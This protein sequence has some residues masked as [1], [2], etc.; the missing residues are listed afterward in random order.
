MGIKSITSQGYILIWFGLKTFSLQEGLLSINLDSEINGIYIYI[1]I[2]IYTHTSVSL[3]TNDKMWAYSYIS[4]AVSF[5][6]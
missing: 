5:Q 1:Y 6:I 3:E 2:Y 4:F